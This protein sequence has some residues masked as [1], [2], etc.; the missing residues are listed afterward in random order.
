M[1]ENVNAEDHHKT[2]NEVEIEAHVKEIN[3]FIENHQ[4]SNDN[5]GKEEEEEELPT[6]NLSENIP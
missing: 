2:A 5:D 6:T 1:Y 4:Q 3:K